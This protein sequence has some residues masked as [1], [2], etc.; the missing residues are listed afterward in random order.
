MVHESRGLSQS[1][2]CKLG[3][4]GDFAQQKTEIAL[5]PACRGTALYNDMNLLDKDTKVIS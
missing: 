3:L 2:R 4:A 1:K 5:D